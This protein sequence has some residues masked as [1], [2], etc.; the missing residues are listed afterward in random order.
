MHWETYLSDQTNTQTVIF[1]NL[2]AK[3]RFSTKWH[4]YNSVIPLTDDGQHLGTF[5][6]DMYSINLKICGVPPPSLYI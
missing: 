2:R 1:F 5:C 4:R 6:S 3:M